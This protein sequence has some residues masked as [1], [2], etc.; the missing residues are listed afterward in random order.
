[1]KW[2]YY[3]VWWVM[4]AYESTVAYA[5][6]HFVA[7]NLSSVWTGIQAFF[8]SL[9]FPEWARSLDEFWPVLVDH[10]KKLLSAIREVFAFFGGA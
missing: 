3:P 7:W 5:K 6:A 9:A 10:S 2:F 4:V 8:L 1:M